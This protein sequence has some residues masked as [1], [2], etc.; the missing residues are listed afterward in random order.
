MQWVNRAHYYQLLPVY[1]RFITPTGNE[2]PDQ[3]QSVEKIIT[4]ITGF[5][6]FFQQSLPY[7]TYI[8]LIYAYII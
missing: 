3:F 4:S 1:Y 7:Y 8:L 6:S 2:K 5:C